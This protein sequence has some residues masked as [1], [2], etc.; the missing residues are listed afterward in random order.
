MK[1]RALLAPGLIVGALSIPSVASA[2]IRLDMPPSFQVQN[3]AGDPQKSGPCGGPGTKSNVVTNFHAGDTV[4]FEWT[5]TLAHGGHYRFA[6][7]LKGEADVPPDPKVVAQGG[8]SISAP[9]QNPP[10]FPVLADGIYPHAAADI[11]SGKK[12][13]Y[14]LKLPAG[15]TCTACLLQITQFMTDH[16]SNTGGNDGYFYHHCAAVTIAAA[17][18]PGDAAAPADAGARDASKPLDTAATGGAGGSTGGTGGSTGGAGGSTG[19][20]SG[21]TGGASGSTG[22]ASGNTGGARGTGGA[23]GGAGGEGT[24]GSDETGGSSPKPSK[25]SGGCS[26]GGSGAGGWLL[27][28]A[29]AGYFRYRARR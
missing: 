7:G 28:L 14:D 10:V 4:H 9:I 16:G 20:A 17:G 23:S 1:A 21:S 29:L 5:E 11:S 22:G 15:M 8:T 2:H 3:S 6:I 19:G 13:T 12:W 18:A 27:L 25:S 26:Y 24:G